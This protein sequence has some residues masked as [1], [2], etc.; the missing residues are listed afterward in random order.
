M[1]STSLFVFSPPKY[2]SES[3]GSDPAGIL[4]FLRWRYSYFGIFR[5]LEAFLSSTDKRL[6][7]FIDFL[8][9]PERVMT[10]IIWLLLGIF[11]CFLRNLFVEKITCFHKFIESGRGI[12]KTWFAKFHSNQSLL[13]MFAIII[14]FDWIYKFKLTVCP[15]YNCWHYWN[16]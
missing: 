3:K 7:N 12:H 10:A 8:L 9:K 15:S 1:L 5:R 6:D 16:R 4:L 11:F 13:G 14:N 2:L